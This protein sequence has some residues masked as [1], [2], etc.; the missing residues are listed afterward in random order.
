L[1]QVRVRRSGGTWEAL[2]RLPELIPEEAA[3]TKVVRV[4]DPACLRLHAD[5][6]K[7]SAICYFDRA[8]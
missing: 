8:L 6:L 7:Q 5:A 4:I 3:W 2:N 1:A